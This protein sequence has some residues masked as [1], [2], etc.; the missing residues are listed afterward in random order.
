[1]VEV[2]LKLDDS[3]IEGHDI[4]GLQDLIDRMI[5]KHSLT[6]GAAYDLVD[7][8][9]AAY[10]EGFDNAEKDAAEEAAGADI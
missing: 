6:L 9:K 7:L 3:Y 5:R 2:K 10:I 1:M 8:A 4:K